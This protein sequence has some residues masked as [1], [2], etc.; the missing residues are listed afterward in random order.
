[1]PNYR[2][3]PLAVLLG[4]AAVLQGCAF[5]RW[6]SSVEVGKGAVTGGIQW[7]SGLEDLPGY[8]P[9]PV[10]VLR[11]WPTEQSGRAEARRRAH[12]HPIARTRVTKN[13]TFRFVLS[14]GRYTLMAYPCGNYHPVQKVTVKVGVVVKADIHNSCM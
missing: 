2:R 8:A 13:Q 1:M 3:M 10:I 14:P 12:L 6:D 7:C 9:G 4:L 5:P 11:G